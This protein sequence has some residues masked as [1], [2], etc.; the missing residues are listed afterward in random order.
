MVKIIDVG[1]TK[2]A[3]GVYRVAKDYVIRERSMQILTSSP[4]RNDTGSINSWAGCEAG[5]REWASGVT[6]ESTILVSLAVSGAKID[7]A[8]LVKPPN[9]A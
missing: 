3:L 1:Q 5:N 9:G 8:G 2:R 7:V 4:I 6:S